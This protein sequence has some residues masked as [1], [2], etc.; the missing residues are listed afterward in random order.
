MKPWMVTAE[1]YDKLA[2]GLAYSEPTMIPGRGP[3]ERRLAE[4]CELAAARKL[5]AAVRALYE[6]ISA[7]WVDECKW[8]CNGCSAF[9]VNRVSGELVHDTDCA[10]LGLDALHEEVTSASEGVVP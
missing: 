7:E 5:M 10:M 8:G 1:E 2:A 3:Y 6:K 4:L 9:L